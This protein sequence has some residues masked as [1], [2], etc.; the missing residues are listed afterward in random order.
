[1]TAVSAPKSAVH[2]P[3]AGAVVTDVILP[4]VTT[5]N[6]YIHVAATADL[7]RHAG[8]TALLLLD[9]QAGE[10]VGIITAAD[11]AAPS[12]MP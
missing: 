2:P 6:Q 3:P 10:P 5:V 7:I 9:A 8:T 4:P 12:R 11:I 1:M